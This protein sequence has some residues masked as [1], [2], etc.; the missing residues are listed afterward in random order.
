MG[1]DLIVCRNVTIYFTKETQEDIY[2]KMNSSLN[3]GGLLFIGATENLICHR[4]LGFQ[5]I[6]H[7]FYKKDMDL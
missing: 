2:I 5:K 3:P 6:S 1:Y 4:E 7:W